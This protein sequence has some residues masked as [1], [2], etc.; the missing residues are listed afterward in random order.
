MVKASNL[1]EH[2]AFEWATCYPDEPQ[3]E[4]EF[5][6]ALPMRRWRFDFA[7]PQERVSLECEGGVWT[8]GAHTRG[9]HYTEDCEKYSSAAIRG[10]CVIRATGDMVKS[11]LAASLVKT[12]LAEARQPVLR[13]VEPVQP[14]KRAKKPGKAPA[15]SRA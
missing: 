14:A 15:R 5:Y 11:G 2:F 12:A 7:W 6:F 10:W 8:R 3:P 9:A 4:R 1:E 13:K